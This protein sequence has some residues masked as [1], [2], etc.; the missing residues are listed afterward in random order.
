MSSGS[1]R[2]AAR[3]SWP[4]ASRPEVAA[5]SICPLS[6]S[7]RARWRSSIASASASASRPSAASK[8]AGVQVRVGGGQGSFGASRRVR[9]QGDR[10]LQERRRGRHSAAG[11]GPLGGP[12]ELGGHVLV[13]PGRGGGQVPDPT[14]RF[15]L[16]VDRLGQ[17]EVGGA[18]VLGGP[19][20][21]RGG[22]HQRV[23]EP[24]AGVD[25]EQ[26]LVSAGAAAVG[27]RPTEVRRP[28]Q[29]GGVPG[30]VRG[31]QQHQL[32]GRLRAAR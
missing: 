11:L 1:S 32:P 13:R 14:V 4:G 30:G 10:P 5:R 20:G 6:R 15:G 8:V 28:P 18:A 12:L 7:T 24:H 16:G 3:S 29:Q 26:L 27:P 31:R 17:G 19:G 9:G 25:L 2:R 22:A 21:V 23:P